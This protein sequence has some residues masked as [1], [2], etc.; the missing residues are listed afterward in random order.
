MASRKIDGMKVVDAKRR[1]A[2][3]ITPQDIRAGDGVKTT[4]SCA[5]ARCLK[6]VEGV[7][8]ARVFVH[9]TYLRTGNKWVRYRTASAL[10]DEIIAFDR[11]GS[12]TAGDYE[13]RAPAPSQRLGAQQGSQPKTARTG[14]KK[15]RAAPHYVSGIRHSR[16]Y[17]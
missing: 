7:T 15:Q 16:A 2:I 1:L 4:R 12:F 17:L 5:A 13:F 14:K 6:R 8:D 3:S 10:R 9:V 11:G